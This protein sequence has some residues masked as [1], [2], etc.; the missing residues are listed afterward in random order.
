[1]G[2]LNRIGRAFRVAVASSDA[3][4]IVGAIRG[5]LAVGY[6]P[7]SGIVPGLRIV[8]DSEGLPPLIDAQLALIRASHA[9]GGIYDLLA[10]HVIKDYGNLAVR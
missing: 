3:A 5:G 2:Q 1:M 8:P 4:A 6:L 9:Y 7:D 10:E